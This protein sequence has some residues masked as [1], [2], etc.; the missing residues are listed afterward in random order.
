[1]PFQ[2]VQEIG[3][4]ANN[5]TYPAT[6]KKGNMLTCEQGWRNGTTITAPTGFTER[7]LAGSKN[8]DGVLI[9]EKISDGTEGNVAIGGTIGA[10]PNIHLCEWFGN[11]ASGEFDAAAAGATGSSTTAQPGSITPALADELFIVVLAFGSGTHNPITIDQAFTMFD[12]AATRFSSAYLIQSGKAARNPTFSFTTGP[13]ECTMVT[14]K[15]MTIAPAAL[16]VPSVAVHR[17][18]RW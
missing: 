7:A 11:P 13:W 14:F 10:A 16:V 9:S 17:A 1:M 2:L 15:P 8:G 5:A 12:A 3:A 4:A 18:S 6:P